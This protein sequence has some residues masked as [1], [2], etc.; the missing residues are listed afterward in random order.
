MTLSDVEQ[1]LGHL[2][3]I[4]AVDQCHS[5]VIVLHA[6]QYVG[7]GWRCEPFLARQKKK[8]VQLLDVQGLA[9]CFT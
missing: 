7:Q 2:I 5:D 1:L 4:D 8:C 9:Y 6:L 3:L